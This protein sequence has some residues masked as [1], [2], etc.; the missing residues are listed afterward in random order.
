MGHRIR[1]GR[2]EATF[3]LGIP[4]FWDLRKYSILWGV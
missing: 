4:V 1:I 3:L 2:S